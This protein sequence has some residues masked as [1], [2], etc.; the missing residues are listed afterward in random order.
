VVRR[1]VGSRNLVTVEALVHYE[2]CRAKNTTINI[3]DSHCVLKVK[4]F[5]LRA[6]V[7]LEIKITNDAATPG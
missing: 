3:C 6:L 4:Q 7:N 2:G 5:N 1:C